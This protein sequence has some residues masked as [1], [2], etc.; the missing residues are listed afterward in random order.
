MEYDEDDLRRELSKYDFASCWC[1]EDATCHVDV[2]V[3]PTNGRS[4]ALLERLTSQIAIIM[5]C[6]QR[7]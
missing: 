2:I 5:K 3:E 1:R 7:I 6:R 4:C